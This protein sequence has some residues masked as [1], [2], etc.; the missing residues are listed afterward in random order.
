MPLD[1]QTPRPRHEPPQWWILW[2]ALSFAAA[3]LIL[4][5][6]IVWRYS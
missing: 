6:V 4:R 5:F 2:T 1:Y 3:A